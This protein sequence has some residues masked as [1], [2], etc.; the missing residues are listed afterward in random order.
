M[1][2]DHVRSPV[3]HAH[4][5][6]CCALWRPRIQCVGQRG[7]QCGP[8]QRPAWHSKGPLPLNSP[9]AAQGESGGQVGDSHEQRHRDCD[10]HQ[11]S[12]ACA[13]ELASGWF[14]RTLLF[15]AF[16]TGSWTLCSFWRA[17]WTMHLVVWDSSLSASTYPVQRPTFPA[18]EAWKDAFMSRASKL[19]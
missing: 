5:R 3:C 13:P 10:E 7:A 12:V 17:A 19:R 11:L 15:R 4:H 1:A 6:S 2:G 8:A 9:N 16:T 14:A 18:T